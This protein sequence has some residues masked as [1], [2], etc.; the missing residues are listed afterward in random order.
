VSETTG[1][2]PAI[3]IRRLDAHH[4]PA[5]VRVINIAAEWYAEFLPPG[6]LDG[7]EMSLAEWTAE[8][9]RMAWYGAFVD[10]ELIGVMGLEYSGDAALLRH[11]YVLPQHQR[12]GV[13]ARLH[14]TLE[15]SVEGVDSII[16]GT[17]A[18]NHKARRALERA[19]YRP[20][21][22]PEAVLRRYYDISEARLRS[23]VTYEKR[24]G[25]A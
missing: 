8:S 23:S 14:E 13:A 9:R 16:V 22:D 7:P 10:D 25:N 1:D 5:A 4:G 24:R 19:G 6:D 3:T 15:A 18:D 11:A 21:A 2:A 20:S 12:Q 17:Y